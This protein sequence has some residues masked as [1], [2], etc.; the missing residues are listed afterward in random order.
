MTSS[1]LWDEGAAQRYDEASA[2]MFA[3]EVVEPAVG[4]LARLAGRGRAL[5]LAIGTGRL[6]VPL[7]GRGVPVAGIELSEPMVGA[8][9]PQGR[10]GCRSRD[11]R[12]HGHHPGARRVRAGLPGVQHHRQPAHP[13][14]AGGVLPQR[15][16]STS[17]PGAGSWSRWACPACAGS[18]PGQVAVPFDV[19]EA[20]TGF[21]TYDDLVTQQATSHHYSRETDGSIRYGAASLPLRL[22]GGV[23]PDGA[24]RRARARAADGRLAAAAPSPQTAP[25]TSP[26]GASPE[27]RPAGGATVRT[28]VGQWFGSREGTP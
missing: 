16:A 23:R 9:A 11:G 20:H 4:L 26:S 12:R 2:E 28:V 22:A 25:A 15:R 3:P 18:P 7:R 19:S 14:R 24:A 6:A 10:C 17:R 13:G 8:A 21:D 27:R 5:E 1:D